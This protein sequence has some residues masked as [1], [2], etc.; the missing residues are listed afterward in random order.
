MNWFT[1]ADP[2]VKRVVDFQK[3]FEKRLDDAIQAAEKDR[4]KSITYDENEIKNDK[5]E[6][7]KKEQP[8]KIVKPIIKDLVE[9]AV[10]SGDPNGAKISSWGRIKPLRFQSFTSLMADLYQDINRVSSFSRCLNGTFPWRKCS[11]NGLGRLTQRRRFVFITLLIW[12]NIPNI[13]MEK[14]FQG[15]VPLRNLLNE[16]TQFMY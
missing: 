12:V 5:M 2:A 7:D 11:V 15:N 10:S 1:I 3:W 9:K 8:E 4:P 13:L 6:D 16:D 14:Y